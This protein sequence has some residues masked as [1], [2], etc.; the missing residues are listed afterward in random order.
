M[1]V[2][3]CRFTDIVYLSKLS[4]RISMM[5]SKHPITECPIH[6]TKIRFKAELKAPLKETKKGSAVK[7][8][9]PYAAKII[10]QLARASSTGHREL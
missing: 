9:L 10:Q 3:K 6:C 8:A 2:W 1:G 4:K 7:A 5:P